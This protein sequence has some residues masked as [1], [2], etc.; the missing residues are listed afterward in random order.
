MEDPEEIARREA[1][2]Q[3]SRMRRGR[4]VAH[5]ATSHDDAEAWDLDFWQAQ[6]PEERLSA[7]VALRRDFEAVDAGRSRE[8][9]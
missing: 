5:R 4:L 9:R 7:L 3:R 1:L 8:G 2:A 6:S